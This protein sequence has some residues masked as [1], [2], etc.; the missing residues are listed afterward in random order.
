MATTGWF[1]ALRVLRIVLLT[2][3]LPPLI[4]GVAVGSVLLYFLGGL[5]WWSWTSLVWAA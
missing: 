1:L 2:V 3:V 4:V 5:G